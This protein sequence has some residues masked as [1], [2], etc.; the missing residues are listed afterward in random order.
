MLL[1]LEK[2]GYSFGDFVV[3]LI[4]Q[5]LIIYLVFFY[6]DVYW[7]LFVIVVMIIFVIGLMGVFVFILLIGIVVDCMVSCW[8]KFWLW[9]LWIVILFGVLLLFVFSMFELGECVKVIYVVV[10][11]GLLMFVYVVNNLLYFVFSGVLIGSMVQCNSLLVY[12]FVVVMI[13]QFIIQV[14]LLLLVLIFGEGD[15]VF[16]FEWVMIVFVVVG[17]FF[18]LIIFVIM[19]EWIVLVKEQIGGVLQDLVDLV[20]NWLWKVMLV[21]MVLVFI[22]LVLKGGIYVYYF[23]YYMSESVLVGF[24]DSFGFNCFIIGLNVVFNGWGLFGFIWFMDLVMLVFS[25]FN[26]CGIFCMIFGIGIFCCLVD[27]FG[28]CDVFG[29]V[30][31]VFIVFLL[32]FYFFLF[33]VVVVV[34]GVFMLYG[35]CYGIIILLLWVMIVDVVD[36]FEWKNYCC[37]IVIIF[38]VMLCGLKIGLSIGGVLVVGI[39]V[40]YGYMVGFEQ[41]F[42]VVV[43]GICL[44]VSVYCFLLFLVVVVLLFFYRIDKC[45]E[46]CIEQEL[47]QCC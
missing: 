3:N 2:L 28:K 33:I 27:C 36:Y 43:D 10:I 42:Q 29:G 30:L 13:V 4:F 9:I 31:L 5:I 21:F 24:F 34:F 38:F 18:F 41:Q 47:L 8:G 35:F 12:C 6:I 45:M 1:I 46:I 26:V 23:Q 16:G 25:L 32:V 14:L 20:W 40:Y 19:C 22:N 15:C 7:L 37:V 11:Y 17:M 44:I 39:F